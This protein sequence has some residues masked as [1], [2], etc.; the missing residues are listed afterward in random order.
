MN[1]SKTIIG[2]LSGVAV[3]AV[4]GIL[5]APDK[6][7]NTRKKISEKS[8]DTRKTIINTFKDALDS[9]SQSCD[10]I[11]NKA[12]NLVKD[13]KEGKEEGNEIF[14]SVKSTFSK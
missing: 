3:G 12:S 6:G 5:L 7:A 4:V 2:L 11:D 10:G 14:N 1:S 9:L 13:V 8:N